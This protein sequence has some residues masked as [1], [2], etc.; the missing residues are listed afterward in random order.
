VPPADSEPSNARKESEGKHSSSDIQEDQNNNNNGGGSVAAK[1]DD[2][3]QPVLPV[4]V[5]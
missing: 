1:L 5:V 4:V 3:M 2:K